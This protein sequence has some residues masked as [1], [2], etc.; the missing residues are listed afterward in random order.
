MKNGDVRKIGY[1]TLL[2]KESMIDFWRR[3]K[4]NRTA[5]L[6]AY[7]L[8]FFYIL[9]IFAPLIAPYDYYT[10][11]LSDVLNP[12]NREHPMGTDHL[13]RDVLSGVVYGARVSLF[14]G[15]VS[16]VISVFVGIMIGS[17]AGYFGGRVDDVLMRFT[18]MFLVIP[19]FFLILIVV[20]IFGSN[21]WNVM[22]IIGLTAWPG[23]ARLIRAQFLSLKSEEFIEAARAG[24]ASDT[25]IIFHHIMPNAIYPVVVNSSILIAGSIITEA[26][27]S[28]LGLGDPNIV[29][30]GQMLNKAQIYLRVAWWMG[31]FPG[32]L[33]F[34]TVLSFNLVGDGLNDALNPRLKEG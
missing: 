3:Y 17:I 28:F 29:S 5:L 26:S 32:I 22:V 10:L 7:I 16:A 14:I 2:F 6:G 4:K 12:P 13:G 27:L 15:F 34:F 24:G 31:V 8:L 18:E 11:S 21:I 1:R 33:M 23:N 19:R 9:A 20:A 30:W 25:R